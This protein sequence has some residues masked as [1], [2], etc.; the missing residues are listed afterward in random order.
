MEKNKM[1]SVWKANAEGNRFETLKANIT[2]EVAIIGGGIT[3][4]TTAQLLKQAGLK[5]AVL[6]ARSVGGGST[7]GSTGNIYKVTEF[8]FDATKTKY[9]TDVVRQVT[10][11][12]DEA[13]TLIKQNIQQYAIDCDY[14][15]QPWYLFSSNEANSS[16]IEKEYE[17]AKDAGIGIS[18]ITQGEVPFTIVNGI[19]IDGQGQFNPLRYVQQLANAVCDDGCRIFENTTVL[20]I[21]E[22]KG[23]YIIATNRGKVYAQYVVHATHTPKGRMV[24]FHSLLGPYREYGVAVKLASGNYPEGIFWGY[25]NANDRYS[26]RSYEHEGEKYLMCI[27]QPHK[28]GQKE[29]NEE[30]IA[31]LENFLR[32]HFDV[33][34]VTN[35]WGGQNYKPADGLPY[36]GRRS[37]GSNEFVATGFS[38]DGLVWGAPLRQL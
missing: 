15:E 35:R 38:T 37:A 18:Y 11:A 23:Q 33:A 24:D 8:G 16:K 34:E 29:H 20:S 5:V 1:L 30:N 6:E 28:V 17:A 13:L 31:N 10:T 26:V 14:K 19:K 2:T 27:G 36:I 12:R 21:E 9:D 3:G 25:F 22:E 32:E 4:I 7:A